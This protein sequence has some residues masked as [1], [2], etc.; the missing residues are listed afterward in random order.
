MVLPGWGSWTGQNIKVSKRKKARFIMKLPKDGPRKD[1][2]KGDVIIIQGGNEKIRKHLV[3]DLPYPFESVA[4]FEASIRAPIGRDFVPEKSHKQLIEP[5]IKTKMGRIIEPMTEES[6][7]QKDMKIRGKIPESILL[8][9]KIKKDE[10]K[11]MI[12]SQ[13][14]NNK[15]KIMKKKNNSIVKTNK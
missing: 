6:L 13:K 11:N 1:E 10:K 12:K 14:S 8:K 3:S 9:K 5:S 15:S 4:D 7:V 2:N